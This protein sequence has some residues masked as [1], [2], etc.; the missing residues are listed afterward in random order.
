M[1]GMFLIRLIKVWSAYNGCLI[2][3]LAFHFD[4]ITDVAIDKSGKFIAASSKDKIISIWSVETLELCASLHNHSDEIN[5]LMFAEF[6]L[7]DIPQDLLFSAGNDGYVN[8]YTLELLS[9]ATK[10][11]NKNQCTPIDSIY[12]KGT[13][14]VLYKAISISCHLTRPIVA[15]GYEAGIINICEISKVKDTITHSLFHTISAHKKDC[16]LL[17]WAPNDM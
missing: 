10:N 11:G 12:Y 16:L 1:I 8:I 4:V 2:K 15:I 13:Q 5:K 6:V 7:E 9:N 3:T 14:G 17:E